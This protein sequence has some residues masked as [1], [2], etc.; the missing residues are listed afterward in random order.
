MQDYESGYYDYWPT[1]PLLRPLMI[2]GVDDA[3]IRRVAFTVSSLNGWRL[4]LIDDILQHRCGLT[5]RAVR[6]ESG[7]TEADQLCE[8]ALK[9]AWLRGP[10]SVIGLPAG[11]VPKRVTRRLWKRSDATFIVVEARPKLPRPLGS[12]AVA[13]LDERIVYRADTIVGIPERAS[14]S[15]I[16]ERVL[17]VLGTR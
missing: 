8:Q 6:A 7:R 5:A 3:L 16:N 2:A 9:S 11:W 13:E 1:Q 4:T 15:T 10:P 17:D 14:D 12:K